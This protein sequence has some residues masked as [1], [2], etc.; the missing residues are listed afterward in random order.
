MNNLAATLGQGP[1]DDIEPTPLASPAIAPTEPCP[2]CGH[3]PRKKAKTRPI[4][5]GSLASRVL[6]VLREAKEPMNLA[7]LVYLTGDSIGAVSGRLTRLVEE[8][9]LERHG[10]THRYTYTL[11]PR[12]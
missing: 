1:T 12:A 5:A 3:T 10:K 6:A 11:G 2:H 8:G 7:Q 9:Y 4:M